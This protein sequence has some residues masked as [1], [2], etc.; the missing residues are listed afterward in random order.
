MM[1]MLRRAF[2]TEVKKSKPEYLYGLNP[3]LAALNAKRRT[4]S[5]LYLNIAERGEKKSNDKVSQIQKLAS[6]Q[7]MKIKFL[8][9]MKL[10]KFSGNRPC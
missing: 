10:Q 4:N 6:S 1:M 3:V 2:S 5:T 8:P 7:N 9:K